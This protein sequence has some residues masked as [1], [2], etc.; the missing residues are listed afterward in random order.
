MQSLA[1]LAG[2]VAHEINTPLGALA[3]NIDSTRR[4][5]DA[6]R[7]YLQTAKCASPVDERLERA[8]RALDD[9]LPGMTAAT[10]RIAEVVQALGAFARLDRA[11]ITELDLHRSIDDALALLRRRMGEQIA[12]VRD[13]GAL[14]PVRC[15]AEGMHQALLSVLCNAVQALEGEGTVSV[16][17]R[18]EGERVIVRITDDGEGIAPEHLPRIFEPG[19]TTRPRG[20]TV[21]AGLG[22]AIAYRTVEDHG[23]TIEVQSTRGAGTTVTIVL[24]LTPPELQTSEG[25]PSA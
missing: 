14:P 18:V 24:P 10:G 12:V 25:G 9:T 13:Y 19:F 2:G 5:V 17:T 16:T 8:L 21:G 3:A 23:G 20:A 4:A 22:L 1:S 7:D 11:P 15:H 6:L